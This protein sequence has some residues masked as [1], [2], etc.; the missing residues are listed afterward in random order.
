MPRSNPSW[1]D[2]YYKWMFQAVKQREAIPQDYDRLR[3]KIRQLD[4]EKSVKEQEKLNR[5]ISRLTL[6]AGV[7]GLIATLISLTGARIAY[8]GMEDKNK[9]TY[10]ESLF[11]FRNAEAIAFVVAAL[12]AV[13][14]LA[15]LG[16]LWRGRRRE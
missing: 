13:P 5:R 7:I 11:V 1:P 15:L 12:L 3:E 9:Q 14:L 16:A 6:I 8:L 10:R 2:Q 4:E